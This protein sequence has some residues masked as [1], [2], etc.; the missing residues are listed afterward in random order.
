MSVYIYIY[1]YIHFALNIFEESLVLVGVEAWVD[2]YK[3]T[4]CGNI[5]AV[6]KHDHIL[7]FKIVPL[8]LQFTQRLGKVK[9]RRLLFVLLIVVKGWMVQNGFVSQLWSGVLPL[10]LVLT[11]QSFALRELGR[12][13]RH[14]ACSCQKRTWT[15]LLYIAPFDPRSTNFL[16]LDVI[17]KHGNTIIATAACCCWEKRREALRRQWWDNFL[18]WIVPINPFHYAC[19]SPLYPRSGLKGQLKP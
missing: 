18:D 15:A 3:W 11:V 6:S 7:Y 4:A 17:I 8:V 13:L 19:Y 10:R 1:I 16:W 2:H 9:L 5:A 14:I 12:I